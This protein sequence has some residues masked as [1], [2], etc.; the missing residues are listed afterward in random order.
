MNAI[1][2]TIC[3]SP[4]SGTTRS[5]SFWRIVHIG[6]SCPS[7]CRK[8]RW[9][10]SSRPRSRRRHRRISA[11]LERRRRCGRS[12]QD[13]SRRSSTTSV[14]AAAE[15]G[16]PIKLGYVVPITGPLAPF[17]SGAQ[18]S[19]KH[20]E[21]AIGDGVVLADKKK[22]PFQVDS[23]GHAVRC[24]PSR[25]HHRRPDQRR[26]GRHGL[27]GVHAR[28]GQSGSR[29]LRRLRVPD[30]LQLGGV[31]LR[32]CRKRRPKATSGATPSPS[33]TWEPSSTS[34]KFSSKLETNKVLGLVL[35]NDTDGI[36]ASKWAPGVFERQRLQGRSNR[37]LHSRGRR[38]HQPALDHEEGRAARSWSRSC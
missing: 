1:A 6:T 34:A 2:A 38:L 10:S 9:R 33:T 31:A 20:F 23:E 32:S 36:T 8:A 25:W 5:I 13:P 15:S 35:A 16:R 22:H 24:E 17:A 19:K 28:D 37:P 7:R 26:Q 14:S 27:G 3:Q 18:W 29:R 4:S 21:D 12:A 11:S 30:D